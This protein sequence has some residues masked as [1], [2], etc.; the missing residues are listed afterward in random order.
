MKDLRALIIQH[1]EQEHAGLFSSLLLSR[2]FK[3]TIVRTWL[4]EPLPSDST[5]YAAV[6]SMG[7]PMSA[8]PPIRDRRLQDEIRLLE[9]CLERSTPTLGVCLGSQ[10]LAVAAGGRVYS[11]GRFRVGWAE[12][13]LSQ[14][15]HRDAAMSCVSGHFPALK[16]HEDVFD[17]PSEGVSLAHSNDLQHEAF[18]VGGAAYGLLFHFEVDADMVL[19]WVHTFGPDMGA[20]AR[21]DADKIL[22][23]T[24]R[25]A[26]MQTRLEAERFFDAFLD[27]VTA[28]REE[29]SEFQRG[30]PWGATS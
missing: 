12:I 11:A 8:I 29:V 16:W 14:E 17:V 24:G 10:T 23:V 26:L 21:R 6:I 13:A 15:G 28:S 19:R 25:R 30:K 4:D 22:S 2:S 9:R 1:V 3:P 18:R 27:A 5:H 20:R 7:G